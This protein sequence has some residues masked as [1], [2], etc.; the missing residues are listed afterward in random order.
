MQHFS[1]KNKIKDIFKDIYYRNKLGKISNEYIFIHVPKCG[2]TSLRNHLNKKLNAYIC[3]WHEIKLKHLNPNQKAIVCLRDPIKRFESAFYSKLHM[4][5]NLNKEELNFYHRFADVN[6]FIDALIHD[7]KNVVNYL[8][9]LNSIPLIARYS[10]LE[11]WFGSLN[12]LE[13]NKHKIKFVIKLEDLNNDLSQVF[14]AEKLQPQPFIKKLNAKP[15]DKFIPI[16]E[17]YIPF[18][19]Q[20]LD[21]DFI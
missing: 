1:R 16:H 4:K 20:Y 10:S 7:N 13:K 9:K 12:Y 17:K 11:Y 21:Q 14:K 15:M 19:N 3:D 6:V 2:G 8:K 18:L 5:I